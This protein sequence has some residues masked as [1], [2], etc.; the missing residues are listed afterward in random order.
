MPTATIPEGTVTLLFSDM[1]GSTRLL[2]RL[3]DQYLDALDAQRHILRETWTAFGGTELGTEGDSFYVVF[4][5]AER[6]VGAVAAGQRRL[7]EFSWPAGERVRVRMG[8]HTGSPIPHDGAYVGMDV[9]R[10]ARIA[11]AAHGGQVTMSAATAALV[12]SALPP[13]SALRDLGTHRLKDLPRPEHIYQ[14][15]VEGLNHDFPPLR[16]LGASSTLPLADAP[17]LGRDQGLES[18]RALVATGERLVTLTGAGGAGKTTLAAELARTLVPDFPDG[19]YFVPL[20]S[21]TEETGMWAAIASTLAVSTD[22][23]GAEAVSEFLADRRAVLVLDN[24]EQ[25][26]NADMVATRLLASATRACV[27]ATSR[28]PLH[29]VGEHEFPVPPLPLPADLSVRAVDESPAVRLFVRHARRVRP[30]FMLTAE[31]GPAVVA[32]CRALDGLPL[33]IELAA[34]RSKLLSPQAILRRLA[35]ALDLSAAE[36]ARPERHRSLRSTIDWSYRLLD[37]AHQDFFVR[38]GV[39]ADGADLAAVDAVCNTTEAGGHD[40]LDLAV[41]I[42]DASLATVTDGADGEPRV[43]LLETVR[44]FAQSRLDV[45]DPD[46]VTRARHARHYLGVVRQACDRLPTAH[47]ASA[48]A[49]LDTEHANICAALDWSLNARPEHAAVGVEIAS[50]IGSYWNQKAAR[51]PD[52]ER[53]L[54]MAVDLG[55]PDSRDLATCMAVLA[56]CLRFSAKES[57]LRTRLAIDSVAMLRRLGERAELPYPMRTLAA[58]ERERGNAPAARVLFEEVIEIVREIGDR[59]PIRVALTELGGY[60]ATDG[61]LE[62]S[63]ELESEAVAVAQEMGDIV[64]VSDSRHNLACTLRMLGRAD[65][66]DLIMRQVIP[67]ALAYHDAQNAATLGEDYAAVLAELGHDRIAA[68]LIGSAD[69][70][71]DNSG[72]PRSSVQQ[73]EIAGAIDGARARL[74]QADWADLY[75]AGYDALVEEELAHAL[76]T[77]VEAGPSSTGPDA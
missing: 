31:S 27:I 17:L 42:V 23:D 73:D 58:V 6:A 53:W 28:R 62:R 2:S 69:G 32:I 44:A 54:S 33:A 48:R 60:E 9:H 4:P 47:Y 72:L 56:N 75:R 38:L 5:V 63:L 50:R 64:A 49:T 30:D 52:S 51:L 19:A 20:A 71:H 45:T 21:V 37:P 59:A 29:V 8:M 70:W 46:D 25:L 55:A 43:A 10:A 11:A 3:G 34:A 18:L 40:P 61:N 57:E 7:A 13:G 16:S 41:D 15:D 68:R 77:M 74:P 66:A 24:L 39:F 65:E 35:T 67:V 12:G 1:E 26:G 76:A 36:A 14:L 22:G